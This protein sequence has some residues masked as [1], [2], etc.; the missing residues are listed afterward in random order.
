M[1]REFLE[2]QLAAG[3]SLE[4]IGRLVGKHPSTVGYW[5]NK[6]G[7]VAAHHAE[8]APRGGISR[9]RL[10]ELVERGLTTRGIAAECSVGCSTVRYWLKRHGLETARSRR[11]RESDGP[12]PS[13][14]TRECPAHGPVSFALESR[15][16]YRC[17]RC[18]SEG[19]S[20]RRRKVK[21]ILVA[22]AGGRCTAC[23]FDAHQAALEFHHLDP[24]QKRFNLSL[25]GV[26]RSIDKLRAEARKCVLLCS[27]CHAL[28]EAG[29]LTV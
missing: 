4:Q 25:R 1:E 24:S 14:V 10:A 17:T 2:E 28:V 13:H 11:A 3:R 7:L 16:Y 12:R 9:E 18:R 27:N 15:G 20:R 5:L 21:E 29:V 8:Y 19:V 6:H 23:G 26:T 22:E